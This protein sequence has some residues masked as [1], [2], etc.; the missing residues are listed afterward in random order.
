MSTWID[1]SEINQFNLQDAD[2]VFKVSTETLQVLRL[3]HEVSMLSGGAFD[4]TVG[5][6]VDAY[7]F[8]SGK[9]RV[10]DAETLDALKS[11][12]ASSSLNIFPIQLVS[13]KWSPSCK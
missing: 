3:S 11:Q 4:V 10:L 7:G 13:A 12:L 5:P 1:E 9:E 8:G 6:L 2:T